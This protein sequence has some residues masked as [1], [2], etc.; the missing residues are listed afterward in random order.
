MGTFR[1][2]LRKV[3]TRDALIAALGTDPSTFAAILEFVPP[4]P[5]RAQAERDPES[6][7][8][9]I[10]EIPMF[11]RHDIPKRK[12]KGE[13]RTAWEPTL[14]KSE[15]KAFARRL[16]SF[17]RLAMDGFPHERAYG[18]LPGRNI[19]ENATVHAGHRNLLCVDVMDFFPTISEVRV[20][21]LFRDLGV[22]AAVSDLLARFLT[23]EGSLPLGFPTSPVLS[24]AIAMPLDAACEELAARCGAVYTRYADDLSF[25]GDGDLPDLEAIR[26]I[27]SVN[28]FALAEHKTRRSRIGQAHFVTGLSVSDPAGSHVPRAKKR[29]LRQEL[30]YAGR[31]GLADHL[32]HLGVNDDRVVQQHVNRLDGMVRFV[33]HQEPAMATR[34]RSQW[35]SLLRDNAMGPSFT[36]RGQHRAPFY[37]FIDEAEFERSG[38]RLLALC[39]VVSQHG[40]RIA[41]EGGALLEAALAD[42]WAAGDAD[43]LKRRGLHFT[44][45]TE[46]LR[47]AYVTRLAS[48]RLEGYVAFA[49]LPDPSAYE[50]TYVRLLG[51]MIKRRLMAAESQF[52]WVYCEAND[53]VS[54]TR[55]EGCITGALRELKD[56]DDRRPAGVGVDFVSKPNLGISAPDFLLG[57]LGRY[58]RSE[59]TREGRPE[60][61]DRLMFERLRDKYRLILDLSDWTEYSRR[62]P[63][64]PWSGA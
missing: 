63:I 3:T 47:L 41:A 53:K 64:L 16:D 61:R 17:F 49:V 24:N 57:V 59:P 48:M 2:D 6:D 8:V 35:R 11:F 33:A 44:D 7:R 60:S 22:D 54:R 10:L 27:L 13:T 15:Y 45:A 26:D 4:P 55:V 50:D 62:R 34:L 20:S 39:I 52:A 14:A 25:S 21:R 29:R 46:D 56:R 9:K 18:F 38:E 12:R 32:H 42:P 1:Y 28:G 23:I 30:Y 43:A 36:P 19:R 31:Y 37:L 40:P 51:A 5:R 58:L